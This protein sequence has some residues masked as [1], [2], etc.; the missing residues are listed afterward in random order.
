MPDLRIYAAP[1]LAGQVGVLSLTS[2]RKDTETLGAALAERGIAVRSGIHCA[3][4]AHRSAGT[5]ST[6]TVRFSFSDFN[7]PE[8]IS[9]LTAAMRVV[10][11]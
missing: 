11:E 3:P 8:E 2:K 6:G 9:R 1:D 5:L 4:L 10:L 7:T